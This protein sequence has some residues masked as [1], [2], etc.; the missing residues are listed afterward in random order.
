[1][2]A[3]EEDESVNRED[4][5]LFYEIPEDREMDIWDTAITKVVDLGHG[6]VMLRCVDTNLENN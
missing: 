1:M 6:A 4:S 2:P 3:P 5:S